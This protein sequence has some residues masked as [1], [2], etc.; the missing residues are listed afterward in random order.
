MNI[1]LTLEEL[2]RCELMINHPLGGNRA[3]RL[4]TR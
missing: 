1:I 2:P 4:I 3:K